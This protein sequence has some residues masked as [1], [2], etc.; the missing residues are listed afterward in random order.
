[1]PLLNSPPTSICS[2]SFGRLS[3]W[4]RERWKEIIIKAEEH[5]MNKLGILKNIVRIWAILSSPLAFQNNGELH[6]ILSWHI[7]ASDTVLRMFLKSFSWS[8]SKCVREKPFTLNS[9]NFLCFGIF[10]LSFYSSPF[11][12]LLIDSLPRFWFISN[13][14]S[15]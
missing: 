12:L 7:C 8:S 10:P 5:R 2:F 1:M 13:S 3:V 11:K 9:M 4:V 14:F 15:W 6:C